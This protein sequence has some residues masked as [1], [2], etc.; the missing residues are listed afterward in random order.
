MK[1]RAENAVSSFF[2]YMWNAWSEE[3]CRI[4]YGDMYRHFWNKWCSLS[5]KGIFGA[6]ERFYAELTSHNRESLVERAVSLYDGNARRK[7]PEESETLVCSECGCEQIEVRAWVDANTD[8][9]ISDTDD[10]SGHWCTE[11]D[12]ETRF[13]TKAEYRQRMQAWWSS[14]DFITMER[15]TGLRE[16]DYPSDDGSQAFVDTADGWWNGQDYD[17]KRNIYKEYN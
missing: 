8:E 17:R 1:N 4:V 13:C 2:Y 10:N 14:C 5:D 3:E 11:C 7:Q 9:F 12:A 6:A 16:T 15:I